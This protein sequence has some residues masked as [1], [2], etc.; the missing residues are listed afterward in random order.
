MPKELTAQVEITSRD[1]TVYDE[2]AEGP[3]LSRVLIQRSF[4]GDIEGTSVAN[5]VLCQGEGGGGYMASERFTGSIDGKSGT[6]VFHHGRING[7]SDPL[8]FGQI[9][10]NSG[11]GALQGIA[12][13]V[14]FAFSPEGATL[15]IGLDS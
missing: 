11:T 3:K 5:L 2:P 1:E 4:A 14:N 7:G 13:S 12:G 6:V 9:I 8:A 10:P 15:T